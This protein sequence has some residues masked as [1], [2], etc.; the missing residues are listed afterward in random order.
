[1]SLELYSTLTRDR[2]PFEPL[3]PGVV[4]MYNCGPT[5][6]DFA[7]IGNFSAFLLA[8]VLRRTLEWK[9]YDVKQVMNITDV[10]HMTQD[11]TDEGEDKMAVA[12]R[13]V[14]KERGE[15]VTVWDVARFYEDRFH[16]DVR[17]LRIKPAHHYPRATEHIPEMI[18]NIQRLVARGHAYVTDQQNVY[19]DV[20][21]FPRYGALSGNTL[22]DLLAGARVAVRDDKKG[23][24]DF[25]LWKHDP[26]HLMQWDSPWGRGFPGWHI[27]CSA[28]GMKYLGQTLDIHTGGED[29]IFPHHESE[30]AQAEG[31]TGQPF[32]RFWLHQRHVLV[33]GEKMSKS[34]GNFY[35]VR[36]LVDKGYTGREI[37]YALISTHYRSQANFTLQVLDAARAALDRIDRFA[38]FCREPRTGTPSE[39]LAEMSEKG[40][41]RFEEAL[42][43]DLN[44]SRALGTLHEFISAVRRKGLGSGDGPKALAVVERMDRIFDF[45]PPEAAPAPTADAGE[46]EALIGERKAARDQKEWKRADEIRDALKAR[47][48][49]L[50]DKPDGSTIWRL[51]R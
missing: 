12:L 27:E 34:K 40:L 11:T 43:D 21:T 33:D 41:H 29:N 28:M 46:V 36:D 23:P 49:T 13:R 15:S 5:V 45:L 3:R 1:M 10:G 19:F 47:G 32:V 6:Y 2:R 22:A 20:A 44:V 42:S 26:K 38:D 31:A 7:H 39:D 4:H 48:V 9:G 8:D 51:V 30:I 14:K 25:A 17:R 24:L 18:E 37:R 50:E 16:E 35:T